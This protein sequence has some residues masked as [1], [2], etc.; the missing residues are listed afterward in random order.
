[1]E[2]TIKIALNE[3][4]VAGIIGQLSN[5]HIIQYFRDIGY[6]YIDN[7]ET[8]WCACFANWV[9]MKLNYAHENKL[10]ARS[11]LTWGKKTTEP[12]MGDIVVLWRDDPKGT[13]GHVGFFI[14]QDRDL[15]WLLGGNEDNNV[16]IKPYS[17]TQVLDYRTK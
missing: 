16:R 13:L 5:Q 6:S 7:D 8:P 17:R 14:R 10:N 3:Y 12:K 11:F 2:D 1:M 9:L 15:V 4:G